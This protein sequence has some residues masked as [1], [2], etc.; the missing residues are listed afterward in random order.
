MLTVGNI[1]KEKHQNNN[2]YSGCYS[3]YGFLFSV[4]V[5][6]FEF[7][8]LNIVMGVILDKKAILLHCINHV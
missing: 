8:I 7:S 1:W 2:V 5:S 6:I 4:F 3:F